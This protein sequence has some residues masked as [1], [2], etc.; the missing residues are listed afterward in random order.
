MH[1]EFVVAQTYLTLPPNL[2]T[3]PIDAHIEFVVA[4]TYLTLPPN[5][6]THPI[7]AHIE[8]VVAQADVVDLGVVECIGHC[9]PPVNRR[10]STL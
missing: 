4:Q 8:F 3:H 6:L 2:L 5:L 1:I 10:K 9:P 7:D